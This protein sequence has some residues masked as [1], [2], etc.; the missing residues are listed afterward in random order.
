MKN[1]IICDYKEGMFFE[2]LVNGHK[3]GMDAGIE[4][5]GQNLGPRPK[6]LLLAA[7]AGCS[8]MDVV[9]ILKKMH[10]SFESFR[11]YVEGALTEDHPKYYQ[12]INIV[13]E[14]KGNNLDQDKIGK[15]VNL[16]QDKYCGVIAGLKPHA[17]ISYEI[18]YQIE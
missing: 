17:K 11:I 5:G 9:S 4:N 12:E 14:F 15:A 13:Y 18:K 3:I 6:P 7:I 1:E 2:A 10:V 16:S 8:G